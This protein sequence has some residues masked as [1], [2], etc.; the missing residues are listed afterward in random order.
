M[1]LKDYLRRE[2]PLLIG[3]VSAFVIANILFLL[4]ANKEKSLENLLY[5]DFLG[6]GIFIFGMLYQ[7]V[8]LS[9][10]YRKVQELMSAH[11]M[12]IGALDEEY[13]FV[14]FELLK[15][16]L[17]YQKEYY[18]QNETQ[19]K[20]KLTDIAD[21]TTQLVHDLKV[22]LAVCE[23]VIQRIPFEEREKLGYEIEQM[24]FRVGQML[25]VARA[26]HY[27][28]DVKAEYFQIQDILRKAIKENAEFFMHKNIEI[29]V[30]VKP[31]EVLNDQK[32]VLY[33]LSQI[34]NNSSKYTDKEGKIS[35]FSEEDQKAYHL[36]LR[37]NGIGIAKEE[38][39]R[40]F[41]K[42]YTGSN[43]RLNTKATGMGLYY[44]KRMA[45][46]LNIGIA[47]DSIQGSNTEFILS[48]YKHSDYIKVQEENRI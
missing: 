36:H 13:S 17:D 33:I 1:K 37:D 32:W 42:G 21:Y 3:F 29:E 45:G 47:V 24:K 5:M 28:E 31:Y 18:K 40:V 19:Y 14:E 6:C 26:N 22:N 23:M 43:G 35:I 38:L 20:E 46:I 15:K 10:L 27:N 4:S 34:L 16:G 11:K 30:Q 41:D 2:A 7:Y 12:L 8:N 44:A 9:R 48:F 25:Y 39:N